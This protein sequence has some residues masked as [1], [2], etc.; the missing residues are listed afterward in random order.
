ME[1]RHGGR[2]ERRRRRRT[3]EL[4]IEPGLGKERGWCGHWEEKKEEKKR[5][6]EKEEERQ[7]PKKREKD[8]SARWKGLF[9]KNRK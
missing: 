5:G 7:G 4:G 9:V 1:G 3:G 8:L 2:R 6:K